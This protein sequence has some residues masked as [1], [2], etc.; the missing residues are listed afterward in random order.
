MWDPK[1]ILKTSQSDTKKA[2]ISE[3]RM[4]TPTET[5]FSDAQN[6]REVE[7]RSSIEQE[8]NL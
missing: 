6:K 8:I 7:G 4:W 5:M 2:E 1:K 3:S